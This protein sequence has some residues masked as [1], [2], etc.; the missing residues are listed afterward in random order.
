[1]NNG[2]RRKRH[3]WL[4]LI[5]PFTLYPLSVTLSAL[6]LPRTAHAS[7]E[8]NFIRAPEQIPEGDD[9]TIAISASARETNVDRTLALEYPTN[10]KFKRAWRVEAGSD[11]TEKIAPYGEVRSLLESEPGQSVIA[12]ADYAPDFDPNAAGI[13]Y[14]VVF[15]TAP[16]VDIKEPR[17]TLKAA[18]IERTSLDTP[19]EIDAKT[20]RPIPVLHNWRM[21]FPSKYDFAFASITTKR[22]VASI[23]MERVPRE[24]RALVVEGTRGAF[25]PL[26][27]RPDVLEDYFRHPFSIALW[28]RT[29][30]AD[31]TLLKLHSEDG[32][33]LR[34][35]I[36]LLG[37]PILERMVARSPKLLIATRAICND[38]AWHYFVLSSDSLG[39]L[40]LFVDAEPP[41]SERLSMPPFHSIS[42][43]MLGDSSMS[44]KDFS[45]DELRMERGAYRE[46]SE[47]ERGM[48]VAAPD[49][50][51]SAFAI[52]HFDGYAGWARSSVVETAPL[53]FTLDSMAT[54]RATTSPVEHAPVLFSA[55][56]PSPTRVHLHWSRTSELGVKQYR[57]ELRIG[58][59]GPF[60]KFLTVD[61]RRGMKSPQ[62][63]TDHPGSPILSRESYDALEELPA[64]KGDLDLYFRVAV[65]G[66]N[67]K[68]EPSYS[69]PVKV[70]Y[71]S[72]RDVFVEQNDPEP[73][74]SVTQIAF[75]LMKP[76]LVRLSVFD[77][78]G[79]E[80]AVLA[81]D[82]LDPGRHIYTLDAANWPAGIYFY[83][84]KTA[85][86][87][88]TRKMT[89]I[90]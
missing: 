40:R 6:L 28:F 53:Y 41:T 55:E 16:V 21:T 22:L 59:Y 23:R 79:R 13:A 72:D 49:T 12:L 87:T 36:G 8:I 44:Y 76:E 77:M 5:L 48:V 37:E 75:R 26:L 89:L 63:M 56:L 29:N 71:G 4:A 67:K 86:T 50:G 74:A 1:M 64:L 39:M 33:D 62:R 70:E 25:A 10:W 57:L 73:F 84:L 15:S 32:N 45:I 18:L 3:Y 24:E 2:H 85:R 17:V 9:V 61:A 14:F 81:N 68:E 60:D 35:A 54:I 27:A 42:T 11:H 19:P 80:V 43:M 51:H 82:K 90:K 7:G 20:K 69:M 65:V 88:V 52:F 83:K 38:G 34:L 58:A 30:A 31:E 78:I 46:P 66:F 47:F